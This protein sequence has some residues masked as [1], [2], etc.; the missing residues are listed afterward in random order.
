MPGSMGWVRSMNSRMD[1]ASR[2]AAALLLADVQTE[3]VVV[4]VRAPRGFHAGSELVQDGL[5]GMDFVQLAHGDDELRRVHAPPG[6]DLEHVG[7]E[8]RVE[9]GEARDHA[10]WHA[11]AGAPERLH[12]LVAQAERAQE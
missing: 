2:L 3:A 6:C 9:S 12:V 8:A 10:Q 5:V 7:H 4:E 1:L 11:P